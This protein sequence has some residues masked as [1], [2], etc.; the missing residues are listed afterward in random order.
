MMLPDHRAA[1]SS[2]QFNYRRNENKIGNIAEK[3]HFP[4]LRFQVSLFPLRTSSYSENERS[5][6]TDVSGA[7]LYWDS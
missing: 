6:P 7:Y 1:P 4:I 5:E 3:R 2:T